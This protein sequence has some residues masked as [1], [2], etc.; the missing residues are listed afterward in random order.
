MLVTSGVYRFSRNP[1]YAGIFCLMAASLIYAF[2]W[3]NVAAVAIGA[4]LH[5]RIVLGEEKFLA[6]H[7]DGYDAYRKRV[8][9]YL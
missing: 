6:S 1:I 5:H 7:F 2:S 3:L 9:R 8:R 4:L